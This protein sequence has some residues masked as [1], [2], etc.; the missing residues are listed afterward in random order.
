[1]GKRIIIRQIPDQ[2]III[3][4]LESLNNHFSHLQVSEESKS[5]DLTRHS[6]ETKKDTSEKVLDVPST[7][8]DLS[9]S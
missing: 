8:Y 9:E 3:Q 1:M 4:R 7:S 2:K 5:V 6:V